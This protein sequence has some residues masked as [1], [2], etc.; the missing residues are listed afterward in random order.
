MISRAF[1]S[2]VW[3]LFPLDVSLGVKTMPYLVHKEQILTAAATERF[4]I[5]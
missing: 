5:I 2:A 1:S 3:Y 4:G